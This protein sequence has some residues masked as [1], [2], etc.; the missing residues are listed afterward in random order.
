VVTEARDTGSGIDPDSV[1]ILIDG[2]PV[3]APELLYDAAQGMTWWIYDPEA[4]MAHNY[5]AGLHTLTVRASDW[6]GNQ[7]GVR[8]Y[9]AIDNSLTQPNIPGMFQQPYGY[10]SGGFGT[11]YPAM[12]GGPGGPGPPRPY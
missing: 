8:I 12:P 1:Q 5:P 6:S 4:V 10:G 11:G 7:G 9:F 2:Q 3:P